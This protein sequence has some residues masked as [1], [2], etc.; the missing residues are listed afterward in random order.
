MVSTRWLSAIPMRIIDRELYS[1]LIVLDMHD[2]DV[3]LGIDFLNK[4]NATIECR[5]Q[6]VVFERES[7]ERFEFMGEPI[8]KTKMFLLASRARKM[9]ANGCMG[10]LASLEDKK[11]EENLKVEDVPIV[12]ELCEVFP[13]DLLGLGRLSSRLSSYLVQGRSRKCHI[14]W[15]QPSWKKYIS[16]WKSFL[17]EFIRPSHSLWGALVFFVNKMDGSMRLCIDYW[18]LNKVT[19]RNK[20]SLP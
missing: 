8:K 6:W 19:I 14:E 9:L 2:Y 20:Y 13:D 12:S 5:K 17:R 11:N 10:F 18:E 15:H 3:I 1:D 4:Y 7:E 16:S